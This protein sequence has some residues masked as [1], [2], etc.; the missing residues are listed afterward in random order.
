MTALTLI[1]PNGSDSSD[2]RDGNWPELPAA[3]FYGLPGRVV[4][5]LAPHTEADR[6]SLL[7]EF[8]SQA[9]NALGPSAY[10][11]IGAD[12]HYTNLFLLVCGDTADARK[13]AGHNEIR[14]LFNAADPLWSANNIATGLSSGEGIVA[15]VRDPDPVKNDPGV[16]RVAAYEH[17]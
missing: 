14:R 4:A 16:S 17:E 15:R 3:A 2:D 7:L 9:G 8:L 13:G 10:M 6:A 5:E 11:R 1:V 12:T